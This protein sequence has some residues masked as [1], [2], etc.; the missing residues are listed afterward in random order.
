MSKYGVTH[1]LSTAYH[2][3]TSGHVGVTNR[4]LKRILEKTLG[5]NRALWSDK[6]ED[7]LW[8]FRTAF[9]THVGCIPYQLVYGNACHLPLKLEHKALWALKH[10]NFD[11]KTTGDHRKLQ[12]N[13]LRPFTISE[14]YPYGTA[15]L[16]HPDGCNFKV[17]CHLLK[18]YHG[19][20][21]LQLE[22]PDLAR[23]RYEKPST[24]LTY[25]KAFF[26]VQWKFLIH[27]ILQCMSAKRTA[28]SEFSSSMALAVNCLATVHDDVADDV[29][30]D[31]IDDVVEPTPP[32]PTPATTPPPQQELIPLSSQVESTP[33]PSPH[34]SPI[35]QPSLP[36]PQQPP[37]HDAKIS[38]AL[39]NQLLETCATLTKKVADTVMDDQEDASKQR[40]KIAELDADEDVILEEDD[41]EKDAK[42]QRRLPESKAHVYHLDLEHAQKVLS[43]QET[44]EAEPAEVEEVL[45]VV[46][47]AKLMTDI[48]TTATTTDI[49]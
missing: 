7:A 31:V 9:K 13:E 5:E 39:L 19:G 41:A 44:D 4:G 40:G 43:I 28:W 3:Q 29:T 1:R 47:A 26:S 16:V 15:K 37:S 25:Y 8:A 49:C 30:D 38:M 23:M 24:K 18:H 36:L 12:L 27:T 35:A 14:I 42:V 34:Q 22:I 46:T 2:L 45:E 20:D 10:A 32:S 11:L 21:P 33:P 17:N 6:L 48:V